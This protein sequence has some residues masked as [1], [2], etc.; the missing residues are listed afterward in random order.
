MILQ[1][2]HASEPVGIFVNRRLQAQTLVNEF[3]IKNLLYADDAVTPSV[4]EMQKVMDRFSDACTRFGLPSTSPDQSCIQLLPERRMLTLTS[5]SMVAESM[6]STS[7]CT[8][9]V[10]QTM[11]V[12]LMRR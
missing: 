7:L 5:R 8:W 3:P 11:M 12:P 1:S 4:S 2:A 6:L 9:V 10:L